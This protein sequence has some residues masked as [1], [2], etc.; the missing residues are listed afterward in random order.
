MTGSASAFWHS[1]STDIFGCTQKWDGQGSHTFNGVY[2]DAENPSGSDWS[3]RWS[4][5]YDNTR[6]KLTLFA[7]GSV[8]DPFALDCVANTG[9]ID[10]HVAVA[11]CSV[12]LPGTLAQQAIVGT[13]TKVL[14]PSSEF[15]HTATYEVALRREACDGSVDTDSDG[16]SDC[17]EY[18]L[19]T[20]PNE[21]DT[22]GDGHTDGDEVA[23]GTNPL[24]DQS[25]PGSPPNQPPAKGRIV[26]KK[27]TVP[28]ASNQT[29]SSR[30]PF[31]G[32]P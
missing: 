10:Y 6:F 32:H 17:R 2:L 14:N 4:R 15:R 7:S 12:E 29:F 11:C 24:N 31:S 30:V 27:A 19:G 1:E 18:E 3:L 26:I 22:D 21:Q 8:W 28:A 9:L 20:N 23:A 5:G 13:A 25:Y 16:L